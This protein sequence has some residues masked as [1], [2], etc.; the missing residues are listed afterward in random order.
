VLKIDKDCHVPLD[1]VR[2]DFVQLAI[3]ACKSY[4][5]RIISIKKTNSRKKGIHLYIE[6]WP[7]V[8]SETA[9]RLQWLL[10]DDCRRVDFNRARINVGLL[11]WNKLFEVAG[12]QIRPIF[13]NKQRAMNHSSTFGNKVHALF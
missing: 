1:W 12:T 2:D 8:D 10:G 7:P 5:T 3:A 13:K 6:I 4:H 11:E 9:N